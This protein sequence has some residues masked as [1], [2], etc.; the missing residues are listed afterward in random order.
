MKDKVHIALVANER[1]RPGLECTKASMIR[2]CATP[3]RLV[4]HEF[5]D[6]DMRLRRQLAWAQFAL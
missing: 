6:V 2:A 5:G 1:Y 4:F 3:E